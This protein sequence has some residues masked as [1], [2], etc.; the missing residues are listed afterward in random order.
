M[1]LFT[2]YVLCICDKKW[3]GKYRLTSECSRGC[4]RLC[5][6]RLEPACGSNITWETELGGFEKYGSKIKLDFH[7]TIL[8]SPFSVVWSCLLCHGFG[9]LCFAPQAFSL[10]ASTRSLPLSSFL[11]VLRSSGAGFLAWHEKELYNFFECENR[12]VL[13]VLPWWKADM[14]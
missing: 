3:D 4:S 5:L 13:D 10:P 7:R 14:R 11:S 9:C 1:I 8:T 2:K 6:M 12:A